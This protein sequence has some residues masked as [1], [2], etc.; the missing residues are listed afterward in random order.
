M[1]DVFPRYPSCNLGYGA[2]APLIPELKLCGVE[3]QWLT[4]GGLLIVRLVVCSSSL[5]L[6]T[7]DPLQ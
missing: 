3:A 7:D 6:C 4:I 5:T 1:V 2:L